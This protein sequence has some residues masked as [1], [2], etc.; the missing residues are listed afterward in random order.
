MVVLIL[1]I[2]AAM[3]VPRIGDTATAKVRSAAQVLAADLAFAQVE[4]IAHS[5]D[6]RLV[7]LDPTNHRYHIAKA[8]ATATPVTNPISKQPYR[9][10]FGQSDAASLAGVTISS[11]SVGGDNQLKFGAFGQIDQAANA[12]ITLSCDGFSCT[13]TIHAT[14]G[15]VTIGDIQ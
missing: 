12:T 2:V 5:D 7:V 15:A 14:T 8:S 6:L 11:S 9:V 13:L 10:T 3:A 4:S 1:A